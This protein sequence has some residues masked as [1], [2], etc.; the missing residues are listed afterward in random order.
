M[1]LA[2]RAYTAEFKELAA[3]RVK[4][5]QSIGVAAKEPGPGDQTLRNRVKAAARFAEDAPRSA[6]GRGG[7]PGR[8]RLTDSRMPA[9]IRAIRAG[10]KGAYGIPRMVR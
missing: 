1:E 6:P 10:L 9:P 2:E 4:E 7:T 5:G 8:K 3:K